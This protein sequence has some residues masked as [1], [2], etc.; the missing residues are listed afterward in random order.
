MLGVDL[1]Y[2]NVMAKIAI[3]PGPRLSERV[4]VSVGQNIGFI[5]WFYL[6]DKWVYVQNGKSLLK[7]TSVLKRIVNVTAQLICLKENSLVL[8]SHYPYAKI[9]HSDWLQKVM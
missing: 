2:P 6:Q 4:L 1:K 8:K 7:N 3:T 9:M 5:T